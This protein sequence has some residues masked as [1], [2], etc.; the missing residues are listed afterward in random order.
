MAVLAAAIVAVIAVNGAFSF[1]QEYR[2]ERAMVALQKLLPHQVTALRDG[3]AVRL[4]VEALV[5]GDVILV[6]EGE[7]VAADC[8]VI[9]AWGLRANLATVTGE[10]LPVARIA[11]AVEE[12]V[13]LRARNVLLAGTAIV[14]GEGRAVVFATGMRTE[15]GRIARLAQTADE[16]RTPL[17]REI[18]RVSRLVAVLAT[19]LGTAF[20]AIG[21][22]LGLPFSESFIFGI[23]IIVANVPEGLLPTVTLAR[24]RFFEVARNCHSLHE[25]ADH[26]TT[27]RLGDPTE[28]ALLAIAERAGPGAPALERI[29]ELPFDADRKRM[30]TLHRS[31]QGRILYCKGALEAVLPLCTRVHADEGAPAP[32][33]DELRERFLASEREIAARGE[34]ML[35]FAWRMIP[36]G[37]ERDGWENDLVLAGLVGLDDPPRAEVPGAVR[38]C[39]EAGIRAIMVTGDHPN[40]ALSVARAIGLVTGEAPHVMTGDELAHLSD[41]QLQLVLD[42]PEILFARASAEQKLRLVEALRSKGH[43]VAVTGDG[44]NDAPALRRADIGVAMGRVG[45][46]VA[47]E[48]ADIV[49]LDDNFASIVAAI[50]EG[51]AV[52]DNLRKFLTYILTSNIPEI[53]PYLAFVLA[54]IP[55][56]LTVIQIL[57]V[58]LGTDMVP[59]L[60]LGAEPPAPEVMRRPPRPRAERLLS[61]PLL[62]RAYLWLGLLEAIAAMSAFFFV[63]D[64]GNWHY[65]ES[66]AAHDPLYLQATAACLAAIVLTQVVNVFLCRDPVRSAFSF[67]PGTNRLLLAGIAVE[68]ALIAAIVYAPP[69]QAVFGTAPLALEAWFFML[70]FAAAMLLLEEGRKFG[71][72]WLDPRQARRRLLR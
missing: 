65:G 17:Q 24:A 53:V 70:P 39:R 62:A 13:P 36:E 10:A 11:D 30:S 47:R 72:R 4:G 68:L 66:L 57:A 21:Q 20:F 50:E 56:P 63:L 49:L 46:D 3:R 5:P 45:T 60:A 28:T 8:R 26:G 37:L 69:G 2:A 55:L 27:V 51:R 52:Y 18:A 9:E 43:V 42:I 61:W 23:G 25:V 38:T 19:G 14:S 58:D 12:D 67:A 15:F 41:T 1:W 71:V 22:L 59:A 29:D 7:D 35:A 40:T 34:R 44:V 54:R 31:A 6:E 16:V 48:S 32:L 64:R 33:N